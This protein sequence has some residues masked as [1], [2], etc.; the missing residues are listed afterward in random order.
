MKERVLR[1]FL[2]SVF[3]CSGS[4][5]ASCR[6]LV[7][8]VVRANRPTLISVEINA[9]E[10]MSLSS[11]QLGHGEVAPLIRVSDRLAQSRGV[12]FRNPG[13]RV[14]YVQMSNALN[15]AEGGCSRRFKVN[16]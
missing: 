1:S 11:L 4:F 10:E 13:E 6:V 9:S 7:P 14:V 3:L 8:Q 15:Q 2:V 5:G 12:R 16:P